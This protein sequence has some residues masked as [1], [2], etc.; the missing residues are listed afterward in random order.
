VNATVQLEN[1]RLEVS[2]PF[3]EPVSLDLMQGSAS[4]VYNQ[5]RDRFVHSIVQRGG[6]YCMVCEYVALC[7]QNSKHLYCF[8]FQES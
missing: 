8:C 2:A 6:Y 5:F 1:V 7:A 4:T 3:L